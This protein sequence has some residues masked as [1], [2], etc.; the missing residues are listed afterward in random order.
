VPIASTTPF[1]RDARAQPARL[2]GADSDAHVANVKRSI[3]QCNVRLV[4]LLE[5]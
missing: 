1:D 3:G 4:V 2:K 5:T